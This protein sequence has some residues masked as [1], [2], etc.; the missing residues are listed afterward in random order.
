MDT[1]GQNCVCTSNWGGG[2]NCF[3]FK[4]RWRGIM[5]AILLIFQILYFGTMCQELQNKIPGA[6]GQGESVHRR[7]PRHATS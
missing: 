7:P 2:V 6:T 4:K 5:R 1:R 3:V